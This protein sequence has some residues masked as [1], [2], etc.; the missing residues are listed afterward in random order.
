MIVAVSIPD[1]E[2]LSKDKVYSVVKHPKLGRLLI[3]DPTSQFTPVGY[4]PSYTQGNSG[5]L[6][7]ENDSELL[8]YPL[9]APESNELI[10]TANLTLNSAGMLSGEVIER[11]IG[12]NADEY[13]EELLSLQ[14][15]QRVKKVETFLSAFLT[16]FTVKDYRVENLEDFD[17]ELVVHY[18]FEASNYAKQ[19][20]DLL[21]VRPRV[22][23]S[24]SEGTIDLKERKYAYELGV[25][26]V[27]EDE[28]NIA[29]PAG[30]VVDELPAPANISSAGTT[31]SSE[32]KM[33]GNILAYKRKYEVE[34]VLVPLDKIKDLNSAT[35]VIAMDERTSAV[36]KKAQ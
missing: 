34:S 22:F 29:V 20:G 30:Y 26:T 24:K 23:G 28:F 4:L 12:T 1:G 19:M 3:F 33:Q 18:T 36:F 35:R 32:T 16:G 2:D 6:I 17:K 5:L 13:R 9:Q 10:R 8:P 27:Q 14:T 11:R 15:P 25:P 21:L 7:T 31:Y